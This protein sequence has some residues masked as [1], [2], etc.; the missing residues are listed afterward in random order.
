MI[1]LMDQQNYI[2]L[3]CYEMCIYVKITPCNMVIV[4]GLEIYFVINVVVGQISDHIGTSA[5]DKGKA[6]TYSVMQ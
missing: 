5:R 2:F 1:V 6:Y 4:V 3:K